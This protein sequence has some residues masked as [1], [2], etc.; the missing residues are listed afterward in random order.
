V[1]QFSIDASAK[2]PKK[3]SQYNGKQ[4]YESLQTGTNEI[5]QISSLET[6]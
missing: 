6:T 5:G 2:A 4:M 3:L 1:E